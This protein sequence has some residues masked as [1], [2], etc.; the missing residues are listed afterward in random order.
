[1][2]E[3][4]VKEA[5][6]SVIE[7][8]FVEIFKDKEAFVETM[9]EN[10]KKVEEV[11]QEMTGGV[12]RTIDD[13]EMDDVSGEEPED[14]DQKIGDL[15]DKFEEK[16]L[17]FTTKFFKVVY[18]NNEP[19]LAVSH[20]RVQKKAGALSYNL[21]FKGASLKTDCAAL[22]NLDS[23]TM[24]G[25]ENTGPAHCT[26]VPLK[27][28]SEQVKQ[29]V[30]DKF[31]MEIIEKDLLPSSSQDFPFTQ[32]QTEDTLKVCQMCRFATR[33]KTEL[34]DHMLTHYKCETCS[35]Y[36]LTEDDLKH[37]EQ[38]HIKIKCDQCSQKIRKDELLNHKMNHLKLKS[39]GK[40]VAKAK[41]VKPVTGYGLWQK[42]ERK[43]INTKYPEMLYTDVGREL[44]R[45]WALV[46]PDERNLLKEQAEEYNRNL[47]QAEKEVAP[48]AINDGNEGNSSETSR[49]SEE[50]VQEEVLA[51]ETLEEL[52]EGNILGDDTNAAINDMLN[53][54]N[55]NH[56]DADQLMNIS[57][58]SIQTESDE[59]A[60]KRKKTISNDSLDCP[61]CGFTSETNEG[62]ASH[63]K[64][65]HTF[66][67]S[68]LKSCQLCKKLF[69]LESKL[70]EHLE[71]CHGQDSNITE[72]VTEVVLVKMRKLSWPAIVLKKENDVIEVKMIADD[73]IKV[74]SLGDVESFNV[75]KISNTKNSRLKNA[76]AK[77]VEILK[78]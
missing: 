18:K 3:E 61:L 55:D 51:A 14:L 46:K 78:K 27:D 20:P 22:T 52:Q 6:D 75:E 30:L 13:M 60:R 48:D 23:S 7:Q 21:H 1:M 71:V 41:I 28:L 38:D 32:S 70:K 40:K 63:M 25:R 9:V 62:L 74:V 73:S 5:G 2:I 67:Q 8:L 47:R 24:G 34:K 11:E 76:Y 44:G 43:R 4:E 37:H 56:I 35:Q 77:A 57:I 39:V 45:R 31:N 59:P 66:S 16:G 26:L 42:D 53:A 19:N 10:L 65:A 64:N 50:N 54:T 68:T 12:K 36:Y 33:D 72:V 29:R 15:L 17:V 49:P 69:F 58:T